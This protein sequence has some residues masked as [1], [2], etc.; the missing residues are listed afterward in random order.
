M[1]S[2]AQFISNLSK[3]NPKTVL[4]GSLGLISSDLDSIKDNQKIITRGSMGC[5]MG[6]A[7]GYA[8]GYPRKKVICLIGDGSFLMKMGSISTILRYK[9]KNLQVYILNNNQYK[10]CGGQK[11]NFKY[12]QKYLPKYFKVINL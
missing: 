4:I 9:P 8:L 5:V 3:R 6:L 1:K 7:L 2:Q 12:I 10:S 11:T